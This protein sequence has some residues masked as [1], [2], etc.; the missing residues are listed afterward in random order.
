MVCDTTGN[1][2]RQR[3]GYTCLA[4]TGAYMGGNA[5]F[6]KR[7]RACR[8][9]RCRSASVSKQCRRLLSALVDSVSVRFKNAS[10]SKKCL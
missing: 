4:I 6:K 5:R 3:H 9:A 7:S 1:M 2:V 10:V 8:N